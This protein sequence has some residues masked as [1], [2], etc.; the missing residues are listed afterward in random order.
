MNAVGVDEH[1]EADNGGDEAPNARIAVD[2]EEHF[3]FRELLPKERRAGTTLARF[4]WR[5]H[6]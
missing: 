4:F 3:G 6:A 5:K 2:L 1:D